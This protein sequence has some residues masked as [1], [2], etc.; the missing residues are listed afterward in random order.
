MSISLEETLGLAPP[1]IATKAEVEE[2]EQEYSEADLRRLQ[3][4]KLVF[5]RRVRGESLLEIYDFLRQ[6]GTP[7]CKKTIWNDLH[8]KD[9]DSFVDELE[10]VQLHDIALL[11][12]YSIEDRD[13]KGLSAAIQARGAM[14]RYMQPQVEKSRVNVEVNVKSEQHMLLKEYAGVIEE[15][16]AL[17]RYSSGVHN[18]QQV[19]SEAAASEDG[20]KRSDS[21]ASQVP[22]P[23]GSS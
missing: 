3:R 11:R 5:Q 2:K 22:S 10:R 8:S 14:I 21:E 20:D 13:L 15:A 6:N 17:N 4:R 9:A 19:D 7:A 23:D 18:R 16:A 1:K 12:A